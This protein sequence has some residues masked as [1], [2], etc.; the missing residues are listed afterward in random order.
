MG[1]RRTEQS[2][3]PCALSASGSTASTL[4]VDADAAIEASR[5]EPIDLLISDV[6]MPG[7]S[8]LELARLNRESQPNARIL[9]MSG[10]TSAALEPHGLTNGEI[11][12]LPFTPSRLA[13]AMR[14]ALDR[15][16]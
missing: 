16:D 2:R 11:L 4:A 7:R 14:E 5:A 6:V 10:Y 3:P 8:G 1:A 12:E 9:L 13:E 15:P